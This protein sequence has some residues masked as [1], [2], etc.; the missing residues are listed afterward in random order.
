MSH[1]TQIASAALHILRAY[2]QDGLTD[3][4]RPVVKF[5]IRSH[6]DPDITGK[7]GALGCEASY[8][9]G[10]IL[11]SPGQRTCMIWPWYQGVLTRDPSGRINGLIATSTA[12]L[13]AV[14][15]CALTAVLIVNTHYH[16]ALPCVRS[17]I[18]CGNRAMIEIDQR[19][20]RALA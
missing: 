7:G 20:E 2:I 4:V 14:I 17:I 11:S 19:D 10:S 16:Q 8:I 3:R 15:L 1:V 6:W 13:L 18:L 5:P 12:W 9:L